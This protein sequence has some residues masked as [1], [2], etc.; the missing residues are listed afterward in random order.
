MEDLG[1][2]GTI[3]LSHAS[4]F[5][6]KEKVQILY[7]L[8]DKILTGIILLTNAYFYYRMISCFWWGSQIFRH[9]GGSKLHGGGNLKKILAGLGYWGS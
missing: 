1:M 3:A 2:W 8:T 6:F 5:I 9:S 4:V 7:L